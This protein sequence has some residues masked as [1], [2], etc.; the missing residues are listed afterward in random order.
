MLV[1]KWNNE[2]LCKACADTANDVMLKGAGE[3][4]DKANKVPLFLADVKTVSCEGL[5][6]SSR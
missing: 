5:L 4:S 1:K 2:A 6:N 3:V